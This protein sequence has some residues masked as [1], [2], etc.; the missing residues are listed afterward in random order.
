MKRLFSPEIKKIY[1]KYPALIRTGTWE[2]IVALVKKGDPKTAEVLARD[3][4]SRSRQVNAQNILARKIRVNRI[5]L[6]AYQSRMAEE[7]QALLR[8]RADSL[9]LAVRRTADTAQSQ[10]MAP[11]RVV[12]ASEMSVLRRDLK[13]W[14]TDGIWSSILL[15]LR[16]TE[17]AMVDV[18]K[19]NEES[20][21]P[22][23]GK[24][25]ELCEERLAF[26]LTAPLVGRGNPKLARG[27]TAYDKATDKLYAK[28]VERGTQGLRPS[29]RIWELTE[30]TKLQL[31]SLLQREIAA[32][33]PSTRIA[34]RLQD[35][36]AP[37]VVGREP[38][39]GSGVYRSP[40]KNAMR[41]AR[42]QTNEAYTN[43]QA[44][45][46]KTRSWVKGMMVTLSPAHDPEGDEDECDAWA[47]KVLSP[48]EFEERVPFHPHCMC[49]G[50]IV[51]KDE[52]LEPS[53]EEAVQVQGG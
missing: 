47:G 10:G 25:R 16:N 19:A 52:F 37:E 36:L 53:R 23:I 3:A 21:A 49:F 30:R 22:E 17:D 12:V 15:G 46:A 6:F 1:A 33:S 5:Q 14:L 42:T 20:Y 43:A 24:E 26:G 35:Y 9:E 45:W 11:L 8:S 50:T 41:L 2:R 34:K 13:V 31:N 48:E 40:F 51:I 4:A 38:N 28:L 18:F 7:L 39:L 44:E 29:D 27:S 32:G